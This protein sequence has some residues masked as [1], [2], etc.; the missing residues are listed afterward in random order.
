MQKCRS[1]SNGDG[2]AYFDW[3]ALGVEAGICFNAIPSHV[4]FLNGPLTDDRK[5]QVKQ[6]QARQPRQ[7][8]D[9]AKKQNQKM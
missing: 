1:S 4:S 9:E 8:D 6:R 7:K 3:L 5:L 2:G